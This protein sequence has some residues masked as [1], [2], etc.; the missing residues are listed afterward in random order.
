M[1]SGHNRL[2]KEA[3]LISLRVT[4]LVLTTIAIVS[5]ASP[6]AHSELAV[7]NCLEE[8]P[9]IGVAKGANSN[10]ANANA[11][12]SCVNHGGTSTCCNI[13][14]T[15]VKGASG[16]KTLCLAGAQG[17]NG[18]FGYATGSSS[19]SAASSAVSNCKIGAIAPKYCRQQGDIV[20]Q[21]VSP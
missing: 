15:F 21:Q 18:D 10:E 8:S 4:F 12:Q 13:Y 16:E 9:H 3:D 14:A 17:Y 19:R 1:P 2:H 5:S 6:G 7:A 20:C 11:I